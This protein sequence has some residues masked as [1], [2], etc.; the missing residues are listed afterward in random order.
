MVSLNNI[1]KIGYVLRFI[2]LCAVFHETMVDCSPIGQLNWDKL[3]YLSDFN[4][5]LNFIK[6][7]LNDHKIRRP[8][9]E[10]KIPKEKCC[11]EYE[12]KVNEFNTKPEF[13]GKL[14]VVIRIF[15]NYATCSRYTRLFYC[16]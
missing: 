2:F 16:I 7:T 14:A 1:R 9:Q 4:T 6:D 13:K 11:V 15:Q 10:T 12:G 5:P 8:S 3:K